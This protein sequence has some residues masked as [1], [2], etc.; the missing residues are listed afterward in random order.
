MRLSPP[1][2]L[3][4]A[5]PVVAAGA[6]P[7]ADDALGRRRGAPILETPAL[8]FLLVVAASA[9]LL[10]QLTRIP[11]HALLAVAALCAFLGFA[12]GAARFD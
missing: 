6:I 1:L 3:A 5:L 7:L 12:V 2:L 4:V 10:G 8:I 9:M 11:H